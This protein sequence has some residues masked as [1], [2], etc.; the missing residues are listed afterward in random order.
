M[1]QN[2]LAKRDGEL[3]NEEIYPGDGPTEIENYQNG[4]NTITTL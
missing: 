2:P 4:S 1:L 3:E